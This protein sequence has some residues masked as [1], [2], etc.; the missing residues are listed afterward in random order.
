MSLHVLYTFPLRIGVSGI[1]MTA[2]H[3][4]AGLAEVGVDVTLCCG[5]CERP[6]PGVRRVVE[7][8]KFAGVRIPYRFT[9]LERGIRHH[10][11]VVARMLRRK[12]M[13]IDILHGWPLGSLNTLRA[14]GE[15]G[16][17]SLLERQNAHTAFAY[18]VVAGEHARLGVP[19][20]QSNTHAGNSRRLA[21]EEE[22]YRLATKLACPSDFVAKTF[23]DRGFSSRQIARHQYGYDPTEFKP[24]GATRTDRRFTVVFV[25]RCEPRKGLHYALQAWHASGAA[26]S[27]RFIICGTYAPGYREVMKPLLEHPS[28][29][30]RG[31]V[32]DVPTVL[33]EA[34]VLVLPTVEE[35]S[36]LVTYE[37]RGAGCVVLASDAAG[38][39]GTDGHDLMIH[40]VSDVELLA[41]Q[42]K[43]L[44]SDRRRLGEMRRRSLTAAST[45][46]WSHAAR[47]LL[48]EYRRTI[49]EQQGQNAAKPKQEIQ[50]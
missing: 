7:T 23:T 47:I 17:P 31:F 2:W 43:D 21:V 33:K 6:I 13:Q 9:G 24:N 29:E 38:A 50:S 5:T 49:R 25:G 34:D 19:L 46:T 42:M 44:G 32:N 35:G 28:I 27:G 39:V 48:D 16:I 4:V 45:L 18:E 37:A 30:E 1:G 14:A 11:S 10:D 41:R 22:E 26:E 15:L 3:Q 20:H 36:A 40:R 8:M 12:Q